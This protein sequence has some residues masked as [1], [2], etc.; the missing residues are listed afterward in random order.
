MQRQLLANNQK[1][2]QIVVHRGEDVHFR[3]TQILLVALEEEGD[4]Y[5]RDHSV[6]NERDRI[7]LFQQLQRRFALSALAF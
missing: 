6:E 4:Y 3:V 2:T 7:G 1:Q 5:N